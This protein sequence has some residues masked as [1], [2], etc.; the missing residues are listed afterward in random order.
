LSA[1]GTARDVATPQSAGG[2]V[3]PSAQLSGGGG[4]PTATLTLDVLG[5]DRASVTI[6]GRELALSLRHSEILV[7]LAARPGGLTAEQLA[8]ALYGD[9]GKPVTARAELSRLRRVLPESIVTEPYRLDATLVRDFEMVR[10]LLRAG[11]T[12]DAVS[13]YPG[14]VL[15]RSEAPGVVELRQELEGW[16][17][18][19]VMGEE[20]VEALWAWLSTPSGADD[21]PAWKRFLANIP[22]GDG[23]RG[24]AAARLERL[25]LLFGPPSNGL[26]LAVSS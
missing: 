21:L 23:R 26:E 13:R 12:A 8:I 18:R 20:D 1:P 6:D 2:V 19:A 11:R 5:R 7:L 16:I 25:R 3:L 22:H 17:R 24:L 14:S 10:Q 4:G 15:P 9:E